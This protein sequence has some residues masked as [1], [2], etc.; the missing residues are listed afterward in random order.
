MPRPIIFNDR[1]NIF[2]ADKA[3]PPVYHGGT[4]QLLQLGGNH[5][6]FTA[7][8]THRH[9]IYFSFRQ[10]S[11]IACTLPSLGLIMWSTPLCSASLLKKT[12]N[13]SSYEFS[14]VVVSLLLRL[15]TV[16]YE[17]NKKAPIISSRIPPATINK[18]K[19]ILPMYS[20]ALEEN[21][22]RSIQ[23]L[24]GWLLYEELLSSSGKVMA[25]P[26]HSVHCHGY[27]QLKR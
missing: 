23:G 15:L 16:P 27:H 12:A 9:G 18:F 17:A 14:T 6:P 5:E 25:Q 19:I 21:V 2:T 8:T 7:R 11:T 3:A 20:S 13:F 4:P 26:R 1:I 24:I 10:I 22:T